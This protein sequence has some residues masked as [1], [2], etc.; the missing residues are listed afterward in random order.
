MLRQP[1]HASRRSALRLSAVA[2]LTGVAV[3]ACGATA[4][5]P[6]PT[7]LRTLAATSPAATPTDSAEA[8]FISVAMRD[9]LQFSDAFRSVEAK[10]PFPTEAGVVV[11]PASLA[12]CPPQLDAFAVVIRAFQSDLAS[13][14]VPAAATAV[15]DRLRTGLSDQLT[16]IDRY[17]SVASSR[18]L[19]VI[20][21]PA[22]AMSD[23]SLEVIRAFTAG[24]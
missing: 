23:A 21:G 16:A 13:T 4:T 17:R 18:D 20:G 7:P 19:S 5:A 12:G 2:G 24:S 14:P 3:S 11:A 8:T 9:R 1:I 6:S 15:A 10:C 22:A